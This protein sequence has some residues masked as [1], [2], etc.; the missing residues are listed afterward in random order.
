MKKVLML[1]VLV[2]VVALGVWLFRSSPEVAKESATDTTAS[3]NEQLGN[4]DLGDLDKEF[5][6]VDSDLNTL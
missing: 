1:L 3:I 6:S 5:Q 2:A 4:V